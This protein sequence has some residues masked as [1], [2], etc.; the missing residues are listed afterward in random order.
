MGVAS[1][2]ELVR[3]TLNSVST[4]G[5]SARN[6]NTAHADPDRARNRTAQPCVAA[7]RGGD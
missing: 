6:N 2:T 4:V 5:V 7:A 3:K 1:V